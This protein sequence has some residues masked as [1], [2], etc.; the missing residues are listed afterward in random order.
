[1]SDW[2]IKIIVLGCDDSEGSGRAMQVAQK[3]GEQNQARVIVVTAYHG[4]EVGGK[5]EMEGRVNP[6]IDTAQTLAENAA[7][8]LRAAGLDAGVEVL[9]GHA[10]EVLIRAAEAHNADLIVVGRRGRSL[11]SEVLLG[12]TS[13]CVVRRGRVPVLVAH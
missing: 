3:I 1:M 5:G 4:P 12:S 13:E 7:Q 9:E 6:D 8:K 11:L 2:G 10:C